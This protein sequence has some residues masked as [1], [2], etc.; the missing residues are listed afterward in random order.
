[1]A[2]NRQRLPEHLWFRESRVTICADA[3]S[4]DGALAAI[5]FLAPEG[6]SPP[7]HRHPSAETFLVTEGEVAFLVDGA[8]ERVTA[9]E[10]AFAPGGS[11]HTFRILSPEARM[12]VVSTPGGHEQLFRLAGTPALDDGLPTVDDGPADIAELVQV[13]DAA[14]VEILGPPPAEL[15]E[16]R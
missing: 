1:M 8:V 12:I 7:L 16:L 6:A 15:A 10:S 3:Q 13:A 2:M 4:T 14:G 5:D 11:A 9:G